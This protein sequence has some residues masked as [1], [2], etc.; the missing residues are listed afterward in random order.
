MITAKWLGISSFLFLRGNDLD[1]DIFSD[2]FSSNIWMLGQADR[3]FCVSRELENKALAL[4][5]N[6]KTV[7]VANSVKAEDFPFF[8]NHKSSK[9]K[10][11]GL[12]GDIKTKK[13]LSILFDE[14]DFSK[15]NLKIVGHLREES[16]KILHGMFMTN[17]DL[18]EKIVHRP[19]INT[20]QEIRHEYYHCDVV[21]IPSLHEGMPNVMLEAMSCGKIVVASNLAGMKDVIVHGENGFLFNPYQEGDLQK[22]IDEVFSLTLEQVQI[23]SLKAHQTMINDYS[24]RTERKRY[25]KELGAYFARPSKAVRK[26]ILS[27]DY[28]HAKTEDLLNSD[29]SLPRDL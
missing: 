19:F 24:L 23:I 6:A 29:Q 11:L 2:E 15:Y 3:V 27:F 18:N 17:P 5:P 9:E 12:F 26:S 16:M 8:E 22:I 10:T 20:V 21:V 7:F 13:G 28:N 4:V 14:L 25:V 1:L